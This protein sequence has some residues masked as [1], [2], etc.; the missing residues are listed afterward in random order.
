M[1]KVAKL[2][3]DQFI[4]MLENGMV[5][6]KWQPCW[7]RGMSMPRNASTGNNYRGINTLLLWAAQQ[8]HGYKHSVWATFKQWKA[9]GHK[10]VN[11]KGRGKMIVFW[12]IVEREQ[13]A[14]DG[15]TE[16]ST[17]PFMRYSTVFNCEHA[18]GYEV[19]SLPDSLSESERL[20][21]IDSAIANTGANIVHG[22]DTAC[23]IPNR[24]RI[25]MP[26]FE[27]F[28]NAHGYYATAFHELAHWTGHKSRLDRDLS[29][30][31]GS[32]AYGMEEL[33]AE[34]SAAFTCAEFGFDS[35]TRD[36]HLKYIKGWLEK[37]KEDHTAIITAASKAAQASEYILN[38][39]ASKA[40][41]AKAA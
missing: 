25:H 23:F 2:V 32:H 40:A 6:G 5:D 30:R 4:D 7:N 20:S 41:Q 31:F 35:I 10:L 19:P 34:L 21:A 16:K 22:G 26:L 18:E 3:T 29:G 13:T 39:A 17:F 28:H 27:T 12:K 37:I 11:A 1:S 9:M 33:V 38:G 36:D 14:S 8:K 15:S 24:D